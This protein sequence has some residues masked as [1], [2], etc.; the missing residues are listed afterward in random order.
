MMAPQP[1]ALQCQSGG[2]WKFLGH[3]V[4]VYGGLSDCM[5]YLLPSCCNVSLQATLPTW[6]ALHGVAAF[7]GTWLAVTLAALC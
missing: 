6:L 4:C 2:H 1:A 7:W 5:L 3:E